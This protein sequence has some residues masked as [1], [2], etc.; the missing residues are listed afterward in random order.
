[1][2]TMVKLQT[3][4]VGSGGASS[5]D[6]TNIP[7]TYTDLKIV[8]SARTNRASQTF[9]FVSVVFNSNKIGRAHV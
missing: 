9:D 5:I 6:F 1:M 7:Q 3:V 8:L 2:A 4:T